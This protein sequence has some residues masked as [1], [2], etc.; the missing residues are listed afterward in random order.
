MKG[1]LR[2]VDFPK[3]NWKAGVASLGKCMLGYNPS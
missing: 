3:D 2:A 1:F